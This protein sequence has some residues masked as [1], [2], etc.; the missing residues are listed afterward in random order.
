MLLYR[1][2]SVT[3]RCGDSSKDFQRLVVYFRTGKKHTEYGLWSENKKLLLLSMWPRGMKPVLSFPVGHGKL[4]S[5]GGVSVKTDR[6][7]GK[8]GWGHQGKR[9]VK[10]TSKFL[11]GSRSRWLILLL[12]VMADWGKADCC[13]EVEIK[14]FTQ[15]QD[16][17]VFRYLVDRLVE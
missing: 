5:L 14:N 2:V 16:K 8:L 10:D 1:N 15:T 13:G 7:H 6:V 3:P 17:I 12:S 9:M 4:T 11:V